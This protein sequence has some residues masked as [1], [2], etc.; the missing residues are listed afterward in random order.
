MVARALY[1]Q[2]IRIRNGLNDRQERMF[3][4]HKLKSRRKPQSNMSSWCRRKETR[5]IF[6]RLSHPLLMD[7]EAV[8]KFKV[9]D[10]G[11]RARVRRLSPLPPQT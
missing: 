1:T 10:P 4:P 3:T 7:R 2:W 5:R 8:R 11:I 9:D 6:A